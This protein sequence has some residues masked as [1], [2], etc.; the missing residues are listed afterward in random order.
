MTAYISMTHKHVKNEATVFLT[1]IIKFYLIQARYS[2]VIFRSLPQ[3][4]W[5]SLEMVEVAKY[6]NLH[7]SYFY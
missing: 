7:A 5:E 6:C 3:Q 4:A 1:E 2:T